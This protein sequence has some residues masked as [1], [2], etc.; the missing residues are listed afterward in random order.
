MAEAIALQRTQAPSPFKL[1][2]ETEEKAEPMRLH[3]NDI[4]IKSLKKGPMAL[5]GGNKVTEAQVEA[6]A[7]EFESVFISQMLKHTFGEKES[8]EL[9]GGGSA[10]N[11]Y[12]DMMVDEYGKLI[13][14]TGGVGLA[15]HIKKQMLTLQEVEK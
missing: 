9:M 7:E 6:A 11:I 1:K 14:R 2:I 4:N 5:H 3:Q 8:N 12:Q 15:D 10:E 13:A